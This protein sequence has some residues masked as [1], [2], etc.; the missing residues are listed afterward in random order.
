[1]YFLS[2]IFFVFM[3]YHLLNDDS[4]YVF[5]NILKVK[6]KQKPFVSLKEMKTQLINAKSKEEI[7]ELKRIIKNRKMFWLHFMM[8][9]MNLFVVVFRSK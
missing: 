8:C 4:P 3:L 5:E 9:F 2:F 6:V 1:M 7:E